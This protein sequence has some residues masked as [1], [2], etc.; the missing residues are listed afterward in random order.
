MATVLLMVLLSRG[1]VHS[2]SSC[3]QLACACLG[4]ATAEVV[5]VLELV[6]KWLIVFTLVPRATSH[7]VDMDY[8][9]KGP[10]GEA[11]TLYGEEAGLSRDPPSS[12]PHPGARQ[13]AKSQR[14]LQNSLT[15]AE[16]HP[17]WTCLML[18]G[19][20]NHPAKPLTYKIMKFHKMVFVL[21]HQILG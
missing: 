18:C 5:P 21:S 14:T 16:Y 13:V 2:P 7:P 6:F 12:C 11:L 3:I 20:E 4:Q 10:W 9:A 19:V 8:T 17:V 15:P 1:R